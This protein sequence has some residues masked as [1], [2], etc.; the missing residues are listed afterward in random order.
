V[1]DGECRDFDTGFVEHDTVR[2]KAVEFDFGRSSRNMFVSWRICTS[3]ARTA[4]PPAPACGYYPYP[5]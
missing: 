2:L 4:L 5:P 1:V 3:S